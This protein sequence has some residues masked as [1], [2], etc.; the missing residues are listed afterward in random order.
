MIHSMT[1]YAVAAQDIGLG[2]LQIELR[3]I[4]SRYLDLGFRIPEELRAA[5]PVLREAISARVGR[6]KIE[7]RVA[8]AAAAESAR[9]LSLNAHLMDRLA[10]LETRLAARFPQAAPLSRY[11][12]LRWPGMLGEQ[13]LSAESLQAAAGRL[14]TVALADLSASRAREGERLAATIFERV[15]AL[16]RLVA[17]VEP[18]LPAIVAE[19]QEKLAQR[20]RD[21]VASFDEERIR[22]EV[23]LFAARADVAEELS[24]LATHL[25]EVERA[26]RKG[27]VV[28]K[29]LDFLM[30]E[31][32]RE[33]NTLASKAMAA[34]L[35]AIAIEM[36]L[37]IEQMREQVQNIE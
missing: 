27:G 26:I 2:V 1:G 33:A 10:E 9:E 14:I 29:R 20:L 3:S 32:N 11:E 17:R 19:F 4:N 35:S 34:E 16:R 30:Q 13:S 8:L 21:A 37:L 24:R 36:K 12:L 25:D 23:A 5:E 15:A 18:M 22:Q 28:G 31:L 6:G 7:C